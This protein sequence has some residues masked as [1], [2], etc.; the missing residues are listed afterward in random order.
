VQPFI[1]AVLLWG[2]QSWL[3]A[4]FSTGFLGLWQNAAPPTSPT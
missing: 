2:G 4:G 3:Q 1:I